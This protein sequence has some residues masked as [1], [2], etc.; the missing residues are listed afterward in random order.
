MFTSY[1]YVQS[2]IDTVP[3]HN[4]MYAKASRFMIIYWISIQDSQLFML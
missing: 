1:F 4:E 3:P 2:L